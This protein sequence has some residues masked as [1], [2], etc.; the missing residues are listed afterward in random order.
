MGLQPIR[1]TSFLEGPSHQG[2]PQ[3]WEAIA[4]GERIVAGTLLIM[5][6]P[7]FFIAALITSVLSRRSPLIAHCRV[8]Q[9]GRPIRV[10]KLRTMWDGVPRWSPGLIECL[11]VEVNNIVLKT[12]EDPR[13]KSRFAAFCR[14]YSIDELP[15]LW[16]VFRGE[17]ALIGPRPLTSHEIEIHY[18]TDAVELLAKK[19][20]L[21]GLWQVRGRSRLNYRQ[22]RR[23]DLFMLRKWSV[24]LYLTILIRTVPKALLGTD[25]W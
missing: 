8:G 25:A 11:P 2:V 4:A 12:T 3:L 23:L 22:R 16:H 7:A 19:P 15:Q 21:S 10:L 17:M 20:G 1:L 6:M 13:V 9:G 24:R 14:R 18:G 5:L